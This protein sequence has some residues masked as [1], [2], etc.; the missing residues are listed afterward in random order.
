MFTLGSLFVYDGDFVATL[1]SLG[2]HFWHLRA[3]LGAVY[4]ALAAYGSDF[5]VTLSLFSDQFELSMG[6]CC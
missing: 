2:D 4:V 1:G 3:A 6:I 5:G